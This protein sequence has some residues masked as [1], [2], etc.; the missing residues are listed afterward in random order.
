LPPKSPDFWTD[1]LSLFRERVQR[2]VDVAAVVEHVACR[3]GQVEVPRVRL[4]GDALLLHALEERLIQL[5]VGGGRRRQRRR[6]AERDYD[7]RK[8]NSA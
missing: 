8:L 4:D 7:D 1:H 3:M 6:C 5:I 2:V